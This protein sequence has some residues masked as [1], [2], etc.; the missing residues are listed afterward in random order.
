MLRTGIE[1]I[2]DWFIETAGASLEYVLAHGM[3]SE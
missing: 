3:M 2:I 1:K